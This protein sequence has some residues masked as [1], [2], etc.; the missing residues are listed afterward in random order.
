M[1]LSDYAWQYLYTQHNVF[2][3]LCM[4][5][6]RWLCK[7]L[8]CLTVKFR[9]LARIPHGIIIFVE[10]RNVVVCYETYS[11]H[12]SYFFKI[13]HYSWSVPW[14]NS[15]FRCVT[16]NNV[17]ERKALVL[18]SQSVVSCCE[19]YTFFFTYIFWKSCSWPPWNLDFSPPNFFLRSYL[20]HQRIKNKD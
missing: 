16:N 20:I 4:I 5:F 1:V 11:C 10:N 18:T 7:H 13:D 2:F 19:K 15:K 17:S 3:G 8:K 14:N 6:I 9:K 12:C